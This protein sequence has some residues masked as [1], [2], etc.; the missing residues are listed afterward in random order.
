MIFIYVAAAMNCR[1]SLFEMDTTG[2]MK[3]YT[4]QLEWA[5]GSGS[6]LFAMLNAYRTWRSKRDDGDFGSDKTHEERKRL[7]EKEKAWT[8]KHALDRKSLHECAAYIE[9][10]YIRLN[11][12][13]LLT[14]DQKNNWS[15]NEKYIVLKVAIAGAFYPHYY[16]RSTKTKRQ[17]ETTIAEILTERD[18]C[19]TVYF[20]GFDKDDC[21][22]IY[23]DRVKELFIKHKVVD[24]NER[25]KLKVTFDGAGQK[26]FVTFK[27]SGKE[28]DQKQFGVACQPGFV[29]TEV[30]KS[31][32]MRRLMS[33][34]KVPVF[35]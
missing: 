10:I 19:D 25:H 13:G 11:R 15:K 31:I 20:T 33:T 12:M 16:V 22:H 34:H 8:K 32:K 24:P 17:C 35:G 5:D 18:P 27:K 14:K 3:Q 26:V 2:G 21:R 30:Y 4:K 1:R 9:D 7:E 28:D 6:D 29:L 23:I